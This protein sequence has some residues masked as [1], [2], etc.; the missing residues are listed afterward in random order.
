MRDP[1]TR[2]SPSL[3]LSVV[4]TAN[5]VFQSYPET[6]KIRRIKKTNPTEAAGTISPEEKRRPSP[7]VAASVPGFLP[8]ALALLSVM[9]RG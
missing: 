8:V 2:A 6:A 5:A 7:A 4:L 9:G 3:R 1:K